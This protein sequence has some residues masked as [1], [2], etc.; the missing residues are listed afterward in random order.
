MD[1]S[2]YLVIGSQPSLAYILGRVLGHIFCSKNF[3]SPARGAVHEAR[4]FIAGRPMAPIL[5]IISNIR[6]G[7]LHCCENAASFAVY[8]SPMLQ[9][10]RIYF[11]ELALSI[12]L[13]VFSI[14]Y[15]YCSKFDEK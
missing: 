3:C 9:N 1:E 11:L 4:A 10:K 14:K 2:V 6:K 8:F 15:D 5:F 12:S 13:H 7:S